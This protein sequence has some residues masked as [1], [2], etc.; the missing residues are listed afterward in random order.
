MGDDARDIVGTWTMD[1]RTDGFNPFA[2][3]WRVDFRDRISR[4]TIVHDRPA[5]RLDHVMVALVGD[6]VPG[7][8]VLA[9]VLVGGV[10]LGCMRERM[11][12]LEA[13]RA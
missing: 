1:A 9:V 8:H 5:I 11:A 4:R 7:Q 2:A 10:T 12:R 13:E 3:S 6:E